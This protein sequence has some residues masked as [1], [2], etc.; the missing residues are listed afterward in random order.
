MILWAQKAKREMLSSYETSGTANGK[1]YECTNEVVFKKL[2]AVCHCLTTLRK[3]H[4][5]LKLLWISY[6]LFVKLVLC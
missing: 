4:V 2:C 1:V 6:D 3:E 5:R